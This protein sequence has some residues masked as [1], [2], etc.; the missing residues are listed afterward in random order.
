MFSSYT[1]LK[2]IVFGDTRVHMGMTRFACFLLFT[3]FLLSFSYAAITPTSPLSIGKTL[4]SANGVYELGFFSPN[5]TKEQYVGIWLKGT[6]PQIVVWVANRE[7]PV[8]D[9]TAN[10][11]ISSSGNLLLLDG[12]HGVVWSTGETFAS[13]RSRAELLDTGNLIVIDKISG[14]TLW[15]SFDH[16]SDTLLHSSALMYNL[17]TDEKQVLTS[18]KSYTDPSPGDFVGLITPQ[19][20]SQGFTMRGSTPYHRTGPWAK[21]RFTGIPL[22]DES[23]T[24][25]FSLHQD[26]NGSGL[27]TYF[28]RNNKPSCFILTSEGS[29]K[30]F[31]HNGTDWELTY[32]DPASIC[33]IYG[34]CGPFGLC[35][36]SVPPEC[37]CLKGFVPKSIE[38]WKRGNWTSGCV[39]RTELHCQ[40]NSTGKDVNV[41][42]PVAS[43]KPPDFYELGSSV[44]PEEC[45][46]SC[47]HNCSCVAFSYIQGIGCLVWNQDLMDAVQFSARGELLSI[48][49]A[50]SEL[51]GNKRKKTI[52]ASTVSLTLFV[53]LGFAA[54]SFWRYRVE[55]NAQIRKDVW[56]NDLKQ[57]DVPGL[58]FFEMNTIQSA[59]DSF[60]LSNKLGQGGFGSVYKGKLEDGKE[61]AVKRLSSSSG[62]GKEEF[63]NE[64][65]L[66]SK[67][68]HIN[69]VRILGCC[70]EGEEKLLIYEFMVNK[71]LDTFIFDARK[72]LEIDWPKRFDIIQGIARGLLYLHR[73]S[74]LK[75]IHRDLKVS[76][77]LLD[78]KMNPK[79]SDFGLARIYQGT[80]YQD[81]THRVVGTLGYMSPEYAW[82]GSFSEKSDIY[83][84]GVLLLEIVSG[85]K[86]SRFSFGEDGKTLLAYAWESW[87]GNGGI[88]LLDKDVADSCRP[89][90]VGRCV[91]IGLLCVQ[92][93]PA[94]RPNTLELLSMLTTTSDLPSPKQPTFEFHT[95]DDESQIRD[96]IT[97]DE[98]TQSVILGR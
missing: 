95:R 18:W 32:E 97:V 27:F 3:F 28:E 80:Q 13:N 89:V 9:S 62:Q 41:F 39:R 94:D 87:F 29:M 7:K 85:E 69:L 8:T 68:Q 82:T 53:I 57:Q 92:H 70:I 79:I 81:N 17:A 4:I 50:R 55:H 66:I 54:Y 96:L 23:Y 58:D 88:D 71:S 31:A 33:D 61:I 90:E 12:K 84:F 14:R 74:R 86:I 43:I 76:N 64:L 73:D 21:T 40:R 6:K 45:H 67:L 51:D 10:L 44:N 20:P 24:S 49:L 30:M 93:Q 19:V 37:K 63:M 77:I 38:E 1:N 59:T 52:V 46:Q 34:V 60:S 15:R 2:E 42:Y 78:E 56:R 36:M 26:V 75:V 47:L 91:Q 48:R 65:V 25:P 16:L 5:N 72:R 11:T 98:I 83:S 22:M 35:V